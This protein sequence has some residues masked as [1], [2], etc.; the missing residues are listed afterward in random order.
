MTKL[1]FTLAELIDSNPCLDGVSRLTKSLTGQYTG[2]TVVN[3]YDHVEIATP[4]DLVWALQL[5]LLSD[6][7][8]RTISV[9]VAIYAARR[10]LHVFER[11]H[12][13]DRLPRRA[14][15]AAERCVDENFSVESLNNVRRAIELAARTAAAAR[16]ITATERGAAWAARTAE[17]S[18]TKSRSSEWAVR[19]AV[20]A[21]E[22]VTRA[23]DDPDAIKTE[24]KTY[25]LE[26]ISSYD[27]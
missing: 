7:D 4:E 18:A 8:R 25:F 14:I 2:T 11:E 16:A 19:G 5:T 15:E 21:I 13:N 3:Y 9:R 24:I 10:V 6:L 17:W 12:P 20:R 22:W 26:L 1:S 23:T 27:D